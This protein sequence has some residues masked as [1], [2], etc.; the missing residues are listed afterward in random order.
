VGDG[1]LSRCGACQSVKYC[2]TGCQS[3]DWKK[4]KVV[5]KRLR[6]VTS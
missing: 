5:C 4:H 1:K 3:A 2:S 6:K